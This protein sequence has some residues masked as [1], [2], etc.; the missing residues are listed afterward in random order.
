MYLT[1]GEMGAKT[2]WDCMCQPGYFGYAGMCTACP[3]TCNC[4]GSVVS[5]C[6]FPD[7]VDANITELI[8]SKAVPSQCVQYPL[9]PPNVYLSLI[10]GIYSA[11]GQNP[12]NPNSVQWNGDAVFPCQDGMKFVA[13]AFIYD[14]QVTPKDCARSV[15]KGITLLEENALLATQCFCGHCL[16]C[17]FPAIALHYA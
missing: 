5:G 7:S 13:L 12:C 15:W 10:V 17:I 1:K 8:L 16:L 3:S 6:W 11:N 2:I 4:T 14:L 9:S